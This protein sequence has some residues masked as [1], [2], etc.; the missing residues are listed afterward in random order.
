M[1][2]RIGRLNEEGK[3]TKWPR[4][5]V[6]TSEFDRGQDPAPVRVGLDKEFFALMPHGMAYLPFVLREEILQ[7]VKE[8][9]EKE[10]SESKKTT[11]PAYEPTDES[12]ATVPVVK[13]RGG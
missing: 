9:K 6:D 12:E 13:R 5:Y 2:N 7:E 3:V 1:S 4:E 11:E 10:K 8:F